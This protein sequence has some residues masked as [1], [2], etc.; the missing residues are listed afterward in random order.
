MAPT[1]RV[2]PRS[3]PGRQC[4]SRPRRGRIVLS[5][6][7]VPPLAA[8]GRQSRRGPALRRTSRV[9][10]YGILRAL[11]Q[12]SARAS[13]S[14]RQHPDQQLVKNYF[15]SDEQT[16]GRKA[17]EA[18]DGPPARG[19]LF[20]NDICGSRSLSRPG[21]P[22]RHPWIRTRQRVLLRQTHWA[23][24]DVGEVALLIGLVKGPSYYDPRSTPIEL[25]RAAM[26]FCRNSPMRADGRRS[27]K[28]RRCRTS[29]PPA[30]RRQLRAGLS[31]SGRRHLKRDYAEAES[32]RRR[33]TVYTT[34]NPRAQAAAEQG[35]S[36][37][38]SRLD[39]VSRVRDAHLEGAIIVADRTAA[40]SSPSVGG[41]AVGA[42]LQP[43]RSM[44]V[45]PSARW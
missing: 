7:D 35:A 12:T 16:I 13:D 21:R 9:D 19:A 24:L 15:L 39:A 14:R 1:A 32:R 26:L 30:S 4:V 6:D 25:A 33:L 23:E 11:W 31:R 17:T 8:P 43:G 34:L 3:A 18:R 44:R 36:R 42:R 28:T 2:P 38:L 22:A 45:G 37:H 20:Q 41:R 29:R 27:R 10:P 40:T 5:P